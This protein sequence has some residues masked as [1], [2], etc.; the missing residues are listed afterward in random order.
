MEKC[1]SQG[2]GA[3][4][5]SLSTEL[6]HRHITPDDGESISFQCLRSAMHFAASHSQGAR[7]PD[8]EALTSWLQRETV[9]T[10]VA[11]R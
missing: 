7:G 2:S 3:D 11:T 5:M 10:A 4:G 6:R 8:V 1:A 9:K